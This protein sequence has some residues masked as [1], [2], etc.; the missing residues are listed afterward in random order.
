MRRLRDTRWMPCTDASTA[1]AGT[2]YASPNQSTRVCKRPGA[3]WRWRVRG[4]ARSYADD[5]QRADD[6]DLADVAADGS[7]QASQV[8]EPHPTR[9]T[10][11]PPNV[12]ATAPGPCPSGSLPHVAA[13]CILRAAAYVG[14]PRVTTAAP[15]PP[16]AEPLKSTIVR[17]RPSANPATPPTTEPTVPPT[18]DA[19]RPVD[20]GASQQFNH[21]NA[22]CGD[23]SNG[24]ARTMDQGELSREATA[25]QGP[26]ANLGCVEEAQEGGAIRCVDL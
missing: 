10:Q 7:R 14:T 21:T 5:R 18:H 13:M 4:A 22:A 16:P 24:A 11:P 23:A 15:A 25:K 6:G 12:S 1:R 3:R 20:S 9:I 17:P 19:V 8:P 2:Y 26:L